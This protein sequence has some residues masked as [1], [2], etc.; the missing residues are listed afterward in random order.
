VR[1]PPPESTAA[2]ESSLRPAHCLSGP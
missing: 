1:M 2:R